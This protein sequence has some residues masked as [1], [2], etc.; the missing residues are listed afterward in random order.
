MGEARRGFHHERSSKKER[1]KRGKPRFERDHSAR[2]VREEHGEPTGPVTDGRV[3]RRAHNGDII[4][5]ARR[6][7]TLDVLQMGKRADA[8]K[9]PLSTSI[10]ISKGMP[11]LPLAPL[12]WIYDRTS[13]PHF[14][15]SSASS[16]AVNSLSEWWSCPQP[17]TSPAIAGS[18]AASSRRDTIV[19]CDARTARSLNMYG[20]LRDQESTG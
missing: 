8:R 19:T 6:S 10:M 12:P 1:E 15:S 16:S 9:A 2:G 20:Y 5:L 18:R 13:I 14:V 11:N 3:E 7:E 4:Q 17:E